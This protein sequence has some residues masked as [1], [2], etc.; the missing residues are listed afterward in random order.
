MSQKNDI[1]FINRDENFLR[2]MQESLLQSGYSVM[3]ASDMRGALSVV[4]SNAVG[5]I[6]CDNR[7]NDIS[8]YDFLRF[9]KS[10]PLREKIP[11]IF[12]VPISDQGRA[13]KAFKLGAVDF[14]VYPLETEEV[15][16]RIKEVFP[17]SGSAKAE[18]AHQV[19][20]DESSDLQPNDPESIVHERRKGRR[21]HILPA[22][23]VGVSRNGILWMPGRI[24]NL[25]VRGMFLETPLLGKPGVELYVRVS[26]PTGISVV[27]GQVKH[28]A[29]KNFNPSAGIGI[30]VEKGPQWKEILQYLASL[31]QNGDLNPSTT[32]TGKPSTSSQNIKETIIMTEAE[33][34][35]P[36]NLPPKS[37]VE[38]YD[39]RFYH[40]LIGKQLDN[41]KAVSF[42]GA[43]GMG[44]VFKGWDIALERA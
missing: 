37:N 31:I 41:Y 12:L 42:I 10:D 28:I 22:L 34:H 36:A 15:V 32:T 20:K 26:L 35:A 44:G 1:L 43:G 14:I 5:L 3:T 19:P 4:T 7:L 2:D 24:K 16:L 38:S 33:G 17:V 6:V 25:N 11:F 30:E 40:S 23:H 21:A 29:F 27:K 39:V 18:P 9:L 13:I 8:G